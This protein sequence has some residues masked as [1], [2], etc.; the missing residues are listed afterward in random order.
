M[1]SITTSIIAA[2]DADVSATGTQTLDALT[3]DAFADDPQVITTSA[4][5]LDMA[6]II[7]PALGVHLRNAGPAVVQLAADAA[8][9]APFAL[10]QP[11]GLA[12]LTPSGKLYART[13]SG[14]ASLV[15]SAAGIYGGPVAPTVGADDL[16]QDAPG[17][18]D[19]FTL[20]FA[21]PAQSDAS[22][23]DGYKIE[24][25]FDGAGFN[26]VATIT[27][28]L[29]LAAHF[30]SGQSNGTAITARARAYLGI[31]EGPYSGET[32]AV[33]ES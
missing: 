22:L 16:S 15:V 29:T 28:P 30:Q 26:L 1:A 10:I 9:T 3:D 21:H 20:V 6:T 4:V 23:A 11:G 24:C 12:L 7:E 5:A 25:D 2:K 13:L 8:F 27:N 14:S 17:V 33:V 19:W 31:H 18:S 32:D